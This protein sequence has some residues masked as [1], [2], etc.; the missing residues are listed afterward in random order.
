M[1]I[2]PP[3]EDCGPAP[4]WKGWVLG[5]LG[6]VAS[7]GFGAPNPPAEGTLK[8]NDGDETREGWGAKGLLGAAA[9]APLSNFG[10]PKGAVLVIVLADWPNG[11]AEPEDVVGGVPKGLAVAG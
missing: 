7:R 2:D 4:N 8:E 10:C 9:P 11:K 3:E 1:N 5:L 6:V